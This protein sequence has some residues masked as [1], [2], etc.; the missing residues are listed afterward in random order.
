MSTGVFLPPLFVNMPRAELTLIT[1]GEILKWIDRGAKYCDIMATFGCSKGV[2]TKIKKSRDEI[3]T[4]LRNNHDLST[5]QL[6]RVSGDAAEIDRRVLEWFRVARGRGVPVSGQLLKEVALRAATSL[7][8]PNFKA[9]N[10]WLMRFQK[11]NLISLHEISGEARDMDSSAAANWKVTVGELVGAYEMRD[12]Y[13][14]DE[15]GLFFRG[16]A[17]GHLQREGSSARAGSWPR[18]AS[19]SSLQ[20][21]RPAKKKTPWS[22]EIQ[23]AAML[24]GEKY[25][26]GCLG[27]AT[28]VPG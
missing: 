19:R 28:N 12:I 20:F 11:R 3:E 24:R 22:L 2:I 16:M 4:A 18:S 9:S 26:Q 10:G 7:K 17:D 27:T 8:L 6:M 23:D 21:R 14:C 5:S 1:K 15:T 13:N 25:L